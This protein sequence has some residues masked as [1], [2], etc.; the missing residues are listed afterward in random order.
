[1]C[2]SPHETQVNLG[3]VAGASAGSRPLSAVLGKLL[4]QQGTPHPER[5]AEILS[6][7]F[8]GYEPQVLKAFEEVSMGK[9]PGL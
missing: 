5:V 2:C 3:L 1:M 4:S 8:V 6:A 7:N 9:R